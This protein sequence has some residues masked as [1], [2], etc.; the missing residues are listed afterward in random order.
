[1][2]MR[3]SWCGAPVRIL[4]VLSVL[5]VAALDIARDGVAAP[6][7]SWDNQINTPLRFRVLPEF[8]N[9]AVL[10]RETQLVWQRDVGIEYA[11]AVLRTSWET[12]NN[13]C[14][15]AKIGGRRGWRL[16]SAEELASLT[17][18]TLTAPALPAGHPFLNVHFTANDDLYWT[19]TSYL[20]GT[21]FVVCFGTACRGVSELQRS[22]YVVPNTFSLLRWCVRGG[23]GQ[24][25]LR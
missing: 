7:E 11:N 22:V 15:E 19:N 2:K 24:H 17:D 4:M 16:P 1:M 3:R 9:E 25:I 5:C 8:N 6:L 20:P 10:D 14:L 21:V 12:S 23:Q 13:A 18:T